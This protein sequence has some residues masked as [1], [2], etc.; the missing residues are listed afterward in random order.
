M[1]RPAKL[2]ICHLL[3]AQPAA[4]APDIIAD[5][6]LAAPRSTCADALDRRLTGKT[7]GPT[8]VCVTRPERREWAATATTWSTGGQMQAGGTDVRRER[9]SR[10]GRLATLV[11]TLRQASVDLDE[12]WRDAV[13][14][15]DATRLV[16]LGDASYG[17][18]LA[19]IALEDGEADLRSRPA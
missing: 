3:P 8:A 17:L 9:E 4:G 13:T 18:H 11:G 10:D 5:Q 7:K 1:S 12:M 16:E 2:L 14:G 6:A 19:L 15:A